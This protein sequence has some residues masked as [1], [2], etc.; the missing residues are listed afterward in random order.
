[1]P[2]VRR[3]RATLRKAEFGFLGVVVKKR[4]NTPR[5]WG[6][7]LSAG[8]LVFDCLEARPLRTSCSIV[9]PRTLWLISGLA[10]GNC[11]AWGW[12]TSTPRGQAMLELRAHSGQSCRE[13]GNRLGQ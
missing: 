13:P 7:P 2:L 10:R 1:M 11:D 3:T 5:R 12:K 4:V 6:A 8:V 9:G